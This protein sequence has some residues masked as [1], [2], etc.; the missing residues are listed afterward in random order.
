MDPLPAAEQ[1]RSAVPG[2]TADGMDPPEQHLRRHVYPLSSSFPHWGPAHL[3]DLMST[4]ASRP[5][6]HTIGDLPTV[7]D[8]TEPARDAKVD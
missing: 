2:E 1:L 5:D 8:R 6:A 4:R 3:R 7:R